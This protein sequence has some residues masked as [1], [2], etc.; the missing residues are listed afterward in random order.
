MTKID[1]LWKFVVHPTAVLPLCVLYGRSLTVGLSAVSF[2]LFKTKKDAA[3]IPNAAS[4]PIR[5]GSKNMRQITFKEHSESRIVLQKATGN[6]GIK[7]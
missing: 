4:R 3:A 6:I 5:N 1:L 2:L 7:H